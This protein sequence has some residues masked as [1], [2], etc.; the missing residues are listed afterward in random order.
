MPELLGDLLTL[1][2]PRRGRFSPHFTKD[3]FWQKVWYSSK[4]IQNHMGRKFKLEYVLERH[5]TFWQKANVCFVK[6]RTKLIFMKQTLPLLAPPIFSPF[7]IRQKQHWSSSKRQ[8]DL[9]FSLRTNQ[10]RRNLTSGEV[11]W[12]Q[13]IDALACPE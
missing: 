4:N 2:E 6:M 12:K 1:F 9:G 8:K 3:S 5:Q 7:G 10:G 13:G 11:W